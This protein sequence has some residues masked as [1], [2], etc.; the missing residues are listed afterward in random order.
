MFRMEMKILYSVLQKV[1]LQIVQMGVS[2]CFWLVRC[3]Y[4]EDILTGTELSTEASTLMR[5]GFF[6]VYKCWQLDS[7][8]NCMAC[9]SSCLWGRVEGRRAQHKKGPHVIRSWWPSWSLLV[10]LLSPCSRWKGMGPAWSGRGRT[11][12]ESLSW[13]AE[14]LWGKSLWHLVREIARDLRGSTSNIA[15]QEK[16][17]FAYGG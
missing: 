12:E 3:V 2:V 7:T 10:R 1:T 6:F 13:F 17:P 15:E 5:F 4:R 16:D 14:H 8:F 9:L 11:W